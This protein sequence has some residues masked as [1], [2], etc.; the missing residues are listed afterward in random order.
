MLPNDEKFALLTDQLIIDA[1]RLAPD[2]ADEAAQFVTTLSAWLLELNTRATQQSISTV[3][4]MADDAARR[5]S[6]SFEDR[7][8]ELEKRVGDVAD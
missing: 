3:R 4:A 8:V 6:A 2:R 1:R 7:I 5:A